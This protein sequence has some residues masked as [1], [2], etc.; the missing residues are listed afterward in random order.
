MFT[1]II[2]DTFIRILMAILPWFGIVHAFRATAPASDAVYK[3]RE[4]EFIYITKA[5]QLEKAIRRLSGTVFG[6]DCEWDNADHTSRIQV[7]QIADE[8]TSLVIHLE[9]MTSACPFLYFITSP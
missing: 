6:L 3:D 8:N 7:V 1:S 4:Y 5:S 2:S 9:K